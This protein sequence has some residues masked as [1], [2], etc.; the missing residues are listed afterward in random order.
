MKFYKIG[1]KNGDSFTTGFNGSLDDAKAYYLGMVFNLGTVKDDMQCC[2]SVEPLPTL[3][4]MVSGCLV[5]DEFVIITDGTVN[6]RVV[7]A[8]V[9][10][11]EL[12]LNVDGWQKSVYLP[13][14]NDYS[15]KGWHV[16]KM[17][18]SLYIVAD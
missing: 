2:T 10:D 8:L 6:R 3:L 9:K 16:E 17:N 18:D 14:E 7:S 5:A 13:M 1:F 4:D 15:L 11:G 12:C